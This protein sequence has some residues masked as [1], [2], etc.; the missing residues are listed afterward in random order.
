MQTREEL[1]ESR[2]YLLAETPAAAGIYTPVVIHDGIAYLSGA[3]PATPTGLTATGSVPSEVSVEDAIKAAEVCGANLL[4]V[5]ARDAGPLSRI[6]RI[7]K[8]TGF[9][10]SD[11]DFTDPHLVINGAS[12][13]L[14]DVLGEA[15][16][17]ARSAVGMATLPVGAAVEVEM[18]AAVD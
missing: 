16:H 17:H 15:G 8:L 3:V 14:I 5:F 7:I 11:P 12:Q 9:V 4:R 2:G 18:I 6:T 13:L 10:N 1:L